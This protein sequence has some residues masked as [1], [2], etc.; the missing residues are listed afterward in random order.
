ML[1]EALLTERTVTIKAAL[2][3]Y[4]PYTSWINTISFYIRDSK[5]LWANNMYAEL[6]TRGAPTEV[7]RLAQFL[8]SAADYQ[9]LLWASWGNT[10]SEKTF[11]P[12]AAFI[13]KCLCFY[14]TRKVK[15][16][17]KTY[18]EQK[19]IYSIFIV[20]FKWGSAPVLSGSKV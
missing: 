11:I 9:T 14:I 1:A 8:W 5:D 19:G 20:Y 16:V 3:L 10:A 12:K 15:V 6:Q 18:S 7:L 4:L 13:S 2:S 17:S